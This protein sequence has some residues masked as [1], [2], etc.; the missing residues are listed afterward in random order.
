MSDENSTR[1]AW[2]EKGPAERHAAAGI[3]PGLL[4]GTTASC[5]FC[6]A[7]IHRAHDRSPWWYTE[8]LAS[9]PAGSET[10]PNG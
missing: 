1:D 7:L 3:V 2:C 10:D 9:A 8:S 5:R 6:G 4:I